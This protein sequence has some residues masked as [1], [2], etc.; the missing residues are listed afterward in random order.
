M[1]WT[2]EELARIGGAHELQIAGRREDGTLRTPVV[3][4][5][6]RHRNSLYV[7]SVNGREAAWF[8]GTQVRHEGHIQAGGVQKDVTLVE[9][10]HDVDDELDAAYRSKYSYSPSSVSHIVSPQAR[11]ATLELV[12][13]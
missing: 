5:V 2:D 7:R 11:A 9:P 13:G 6:V 10:A 1:S 12:P 4:W 8:R 3:V